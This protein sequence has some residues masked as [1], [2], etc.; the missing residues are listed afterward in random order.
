[1]R[2]LKTS[3]LWFFH[4]D[5]SHLKLHHLGFRFQFSLVAWLCP[6]LCDPMDCITPGLPVRHQLPE[7]AQTLSIESVMPSNNLIL[8]RPL[9]LPPPIFQGS[10]SFQTSQFF[11]SGG[12]SFG[13]SVSTSVL[14]M[15]IQDWSP[16]GWPAWIAFQSKQFSRVYF[17]TTVQKHQ[18]LGT[19]LSL[20]SNS[21][22]HMWLLEKP[23]L[24]LDGPLLAR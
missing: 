19:Q 24:W 11:T 5:S 15:N 22:I 2:S 17:D 21:H 20:Y 12:I 6:T 8:C 7:L 3:S 18:F 14:P 4:F 1:M 16:L 13:V 10:W 23:W 9:L